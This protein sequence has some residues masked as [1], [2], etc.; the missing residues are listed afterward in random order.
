MNHLR[1]AKAEWKT[2][3]QL[4][5]VLAQGLDNLVTIDEFLRILENF[6]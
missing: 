5:S 2:I 6:Q 4:K 3:S 1:Y